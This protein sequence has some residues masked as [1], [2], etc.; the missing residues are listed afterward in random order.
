MGFNIYTDFLKAIEVNIIHI[1]TVV[2][3]DEEFIS[4]ANK[5]DIKIVFTAHDY[6][7]TCPKVKSIGSG[8]KTCTDHGNGEKCVICNR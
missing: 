2:N 3:L 7:G 8:V 6:F 1:H 5:M 4:A